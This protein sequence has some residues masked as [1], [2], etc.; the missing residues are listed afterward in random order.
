MSSSGNF[1]SKFDTYLLTSVKYGVQR[2]LLHK[3][4]HTAMFILPAAVHK[5]AQFGFVSI[6]NRMSTGRACNLCFLQ[7]ASA[8]S[9]WTTQDWPSGQKENFPNYPAT[10]LHKYITSISLASPNCSSPTTLSSV[11]I[12]RPL[13]R[14]PGLHVDSHTSLSFQIASPQAICSPGCG[15]SHLLRGP[16]LFP[17]W[18]APFGNWVGVLEAWW[19]PRQE[20]WSRGFCAH[21]MLAGPPSLPGTRSQHPSAAARP[22]FKPWL[23]HITPECQLIFLVTHLG[24][25]L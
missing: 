20:P 22:R 8:C 17:G 21:S 16:G 1:N 25:F 23:P 13:L 18:V 7:E 10:L 2:P 4:F 5:L 3:E 9:V 14:S 19:G 11:A 15:S 24:G 6:W 12:P